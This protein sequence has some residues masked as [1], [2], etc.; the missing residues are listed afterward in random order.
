MACFYC[1]GTI[2]NATTTYMTDYEN[3]YIII[4]N[5]PCEKCSQ[6]GEEYLSGTT[7]EK[8]ERIVDRV[9]SALD[10]YKRQIY[11]LRDLPKLLPNPIQIP[12][13]LN[14]I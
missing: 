9:K 6:C 10:V 7:L 5:V 1:K 11:T 2:E 13:K 12:V 3:C 4:K 8:I 14:E